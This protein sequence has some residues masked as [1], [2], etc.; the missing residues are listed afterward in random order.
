MLKK[1]RGLLKA[2]GYLSGLLIER[3]VSLPTRSAYVARF[4]GLKRA[5]R[6]IGYKP[7][8]YRKLSPRPRGLG[9]EKMLAVLR[10]LLK[11][12]GR[13][14]Q[15][16]MQSGHSRKCIETT[17]MN[18]VRQ[19][20]TNFLRR[21]TLLLASRHARKNEENLRIHADRHPRRS[22]ANPALPFVTN[23][24]LFVGEA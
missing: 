14:S 21:T 5:Y 10:R 17:R 22:S 20:Q 18:Q 24:P 8:F 16:I 2:N 12:H 4:V 7:D 19:R 1:L 3:S 13:L 11:R 9:K 15:E 6:L 23:R